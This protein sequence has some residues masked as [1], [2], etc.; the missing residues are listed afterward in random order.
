MKSELFKILEEEN[1]GYGIDLK[2]GKGSDEDNLK[3]SSTW[4][5]DSNDFP[6]F[7]GEAYH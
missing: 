3:T 1:I 6:F 5:M 2:E 4:I 7:V